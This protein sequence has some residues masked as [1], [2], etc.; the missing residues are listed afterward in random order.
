MLEVCQGPLNTVFGYGLMGLARP[1]AWSL[2]PIYMAH[3]SYI[4]FPPY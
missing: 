1:L 3:T 2:R 4:A